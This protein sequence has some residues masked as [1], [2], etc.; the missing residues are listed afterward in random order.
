MAFLLY[1]SPS[2]WPLSSMQFHQRKLDLILNIK[3]NHYITNISILKQDN[4]VSIES[5]IVKHHL[6]WSGH[7][8][9]L[10]D[11]QLPQ[12]LLCSELSTG[13]H[14]RGRPLLC[15]KDQLKATFKKTGI[16]PRTNGRLLQQS[17]WAGNS[18]FPKQTKE[19]CVT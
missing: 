1:S 16:D 19:K 3:W 11:A 4:T 12:Q 10:G 13:S 9:S 8:A 5:M 17:D 15:Y 6:Q 18:R 2:T 7:L 14:P